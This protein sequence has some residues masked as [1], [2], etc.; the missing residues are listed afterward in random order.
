MSQDSD[1]HVVMRDCSATLEEQHMIVAVS[2]VMILIAFVDGVPAQLSSM[3]NIGTW[4]AN[5]TVEMRMAWYHS[6]EGMES[7][8]VRR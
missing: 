7:P 4:L 1:L 6:K 2:V 8:S 3:P 5:L